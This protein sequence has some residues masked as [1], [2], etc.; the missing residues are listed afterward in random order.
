M[1][2]PPIPYDGRMTPVQDASGQHFYSVQ[3]CAFAHDRSTSVALYH[4]RVHGS[5]TRLGMGNRRPGIRNRVKPVQIAEF[6]WECQA[7]AAKDLR[8]DPMTVYRW[9]SPRASAVALRRRD[10]AVARLRE[11]LS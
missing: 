1:R 10:A 8:V 4:L 6:I 11:R 5:L 2:T 3:D 9:L 7:D